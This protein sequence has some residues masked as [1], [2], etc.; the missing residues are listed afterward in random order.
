M[1]KKWI[2][3]IVILV[4]LA[5]AVLVGRMLHKKGKAKLAAMMKGK[6]ESV[7]VAKD[8]IT[9][10]LEETGE[11]QPIRDIEIKSKVGGKIVKLL[12]DEND[13]VRQGQLIAI[14]E[15][16]YD[17]SASL[18]SIKNTLRE[19]EITYQRAQERYNRD[20]EQKQ[21]LTQEQLDESADHLEVAKMNYD[22]SLVQNNLVKDITIE[23]G[24]SKVYSTA[25]G[26]VIEKLV[27]EGE[28]VRSDI[29]TVSGG[30]VLFRLADLNEM[31]VRAQI[32][33]V[34]IAKIHPGQQSKIQVD[35]LPY[36]AYQGSI[37]KIAPTAK[38]NNNIKVFDVDIHITNSD[39]SLKPGMTANV[40]IIGETK[41]DILTIPIRAVFSD[42]EGNDVVYK[43]QGDSVGAKVVIKT[44]I[45]DLQKVEV[46]DGVSEGDKISLSEPSSAK[47]GNSVQMG[48][49]V[50]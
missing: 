15:P 20:R 49:Q 34:D 22:N 50:N 23:N 27:E 35:A 4:V 44:G 25:S 9:I 26:S 7:T 8:E 39:H 38:L 12:V 42:E 33:E 16:D 41:T 46:I 3:L 10:K 31:I 36:N 30:T 21:F 24:V 5:A 14:I 29:G 48:M 37:T 45:N 13:Y 28:M 43:V 11:I 19:N 1:K 18:S 6:V 17:Q 32:N 40:S 2:I 47:K